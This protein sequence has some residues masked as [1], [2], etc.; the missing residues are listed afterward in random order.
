MTSE[1]LVYYRKE[2]IEKAREKNI[3][4]FSLDLN[5]HTCTTW[6]TWVRHFRQIR[7]VKLLLD[8]CSAACDVTLPR[9]V[10]KSSF[11]A[12]M[13][14][15]ETSD[16]RSMNKRSVQTGRR[17][18]LSVCLCACYELIA[19]YARCPMHSSPWRLTV[20]RFYLLPWSPYLFITAT[21]AA[22]THE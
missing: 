22:F 1:A 20:A 8:G 11:R 3:S 14:E 5:T 7:C 18:V 9:P 19:A 21:A 13:E 6:I 10:Y 2:G 16:N 12:S 4:V 15:Y 17:R